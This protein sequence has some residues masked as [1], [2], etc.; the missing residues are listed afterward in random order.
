MPLC[1]CSTCHSPTVD[2]QLS[3]FYFLVI[4]KS[5]AKTMDEQVS[6]Q[7]D[8]GSSGS[9]V[10]YIVSYFYFDVYSVCCL[11]KQTSQKSEECLRREDRDDLNLSSLII[12]HFLFLKNLPICTTFPLGLFLEWSKKD[13][14]YNLKNFI[15]LLPYKTVITCHWGQK[16]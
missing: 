11:C 5:V 12:Y 1:I 6:L 15:V 2:G 9:T 4:M 7:L 3:W 16:S 13:L 14:I 8:T 10:S